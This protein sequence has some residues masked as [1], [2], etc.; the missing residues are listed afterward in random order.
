MTDKTIPKKQSKLFRV[1]RF[2]DSAS[3]PDNLKPPKS[4]EIG[5]SSKAN[6]TLIIKPLSVK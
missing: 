6:N 3:E 1:E 4:K 2:M 5:M